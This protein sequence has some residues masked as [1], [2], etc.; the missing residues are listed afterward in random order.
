MVASRAR[1]RVNPERQVAGAFLDESRRR[2]RAEYMPKLRR[3]VSMLAPADL[4]WRPNPH[5]N[6]IGNLLLHLQGNLRQWILCGVGGRADRRDRDA[7]FAAR[8]RTTGRMLVDRLARTVRE[9]DA[10]LAGLTVEQLL[11]TRVIQGY[12]VTGLRA[13]Y[14]VV[15]HFSGHT[16]QVLYIAKLRRDVDLGF[17]PHLAPR[18]RRGTRPRHL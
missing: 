11:A 1:G 16:G 4:W 9:A 2:L 10:V 14:H 8:R 13:V 12:R 18:A 5:S 6:A 15:E 3:A 7:E 17:Y